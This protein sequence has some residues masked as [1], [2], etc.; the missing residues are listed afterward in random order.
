MPAGPSIAEKIETLETAGALKIVFRSW[1]PAAAAN[2]VMVIVP[3]FN[4]HS[5]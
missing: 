2:G 1:Q 5:G 4:S 3:G